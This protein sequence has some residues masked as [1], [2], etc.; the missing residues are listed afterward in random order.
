MEKEKIYKMLV[1]YD[2]HY[3]NPTL[4]IYTLDGFKEIDNVRIGDTIKVDLCMWE[5]RQSLIK[6]RIIRINKKAKLI[7]GK[8]EYLSY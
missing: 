8:F 4:D 3:L 7:A 2:G 1:D 5:D 6:M